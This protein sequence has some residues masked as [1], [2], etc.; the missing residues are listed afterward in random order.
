MAPSFGQRLLIALFKVVNAIIPRHRL[1]KYLGAMNLLAMRDELRDKNLHD[2]YPDAEYQGTSQD[3]KMVDTKFLAV[4][5][6]DGK[7][8][9]T[10]RPKM[11]CRYM[12]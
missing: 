3:P 9:D 6:S 11:G 8:N 4:R 7:F 1:P 10:E 12:W 2:T 5:N